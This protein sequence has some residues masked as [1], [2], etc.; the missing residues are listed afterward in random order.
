MDK[1]FEFVSFT[2]TPSEKYVG[3]ATVRIYGSVVVVL[4]YKIVAKKNGDG[5]FPACAAYKM[6]DRMPGDEYDDCFLIDSRCDNDEINKCIMSEFYKWQ[7]AQ[8]PVFTAEQS[9]P[10]IQ[11]PEY[12]QQQPQQENLP[13]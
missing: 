8:Q 10:F 7:K 6:S 3:V 4:R 5:Y 2:P 12:Q 1:R 9:V 13:F 11:R